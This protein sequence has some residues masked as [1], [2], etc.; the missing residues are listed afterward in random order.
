MQVVGNELASQQ[1]DEQERD[2][3]PDQAAD[4][5]REHDAQGDVRDRLS[6]VRRDDGLED[7]ETGRLMGSFAQD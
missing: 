1:E 7:A 6:Q 3:A 2:A 4:D 5:E